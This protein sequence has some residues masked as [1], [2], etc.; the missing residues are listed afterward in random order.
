MSLDCLRIRP[1]LR[2]VL[3]APL[4]LA[5]CRGGGSRLDPA[6]TWQG[7]ADGGSIL[8]VDVAG[9]FELLTR[10]GTASSGAV[11]EEN[12][13]LRLSPSLV[14][15]PFR[16]GAR[17]HLVDRE[18]LLDLCN[19]VNL[20]RSSD[21]AFTRHEDRDLPA[22]GLPDLP[23][24]WD[25]WILPRPVI[26]RVVEVFP[27]GR[28]R[29]DVGGRDGVF[30]GMRMIVFGRDVEENW[31]DA[32]FEVR[33]VSHGERDAIVTGYKGPVGLNVSSSRTAAEREVFGGKKPR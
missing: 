13:G 9:R 15:I 6:G 5:A 24:P 4:L 29:V 21:A 14:L 30:V 18:R 27:E 1:V 16:W 33:V 11:V 22:D 31:L 3:F 25:R 2:S 17:R 28:A 23:P 12:D 20:E 26:G 8:R 32:G 7:G 10:E 19:E